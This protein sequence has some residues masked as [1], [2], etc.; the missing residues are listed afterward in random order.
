MDR[1]ALDRL[2]DGPD[3]GAPGV[4]EALAGLLAALRAGPRPAEVRGEGA[5]VLAYQAAL[6]GALRTLPTGRRALLGW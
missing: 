6:V 4:P 2:L 1:A 5:A 3:D